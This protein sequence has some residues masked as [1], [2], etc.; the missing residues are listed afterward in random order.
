LV[1]HAVEINL[2]N[3]VTV[4]FDDRVER[5]GHETAAPDPK[6]DQQSDTDRHRGHNKCVVPAE[7]SEHAP[8]YR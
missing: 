7:K 1:V 5:A 2:R 6:Q 4:D 8:D 3:F